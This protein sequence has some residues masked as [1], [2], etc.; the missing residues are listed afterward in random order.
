MPFFSTK[1]DKENTNKERKV[2]FK[3]CELCYCFFLLTGTLLI[4]FFTS[5][6]FAGF[7]LFFLI[8]FR[9]TTFIF[10]KIF[11]R[12]PIRYAPITA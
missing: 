1:V 8:I 7:S 10:P 12:V 9:L 4:F 5:V 3:C 11:S 6:P 2:R